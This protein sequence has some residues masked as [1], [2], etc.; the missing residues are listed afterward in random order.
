[1]ALQDNLIAYYDLENTTDASGNGNTLTNTGSVAFSAA[2]IDN[3]AVFDGSNKRLGVTSNNL[4]FDYNGDYTWAW[5]ININV[6]TGYGWDHWT[7]TGA[8]R[9]PI[10]ARGSGSVWD[11]YCGGFSGVNIISTTLSTST[12]YFFVLVKTGSNWELFRDN[13]SIG[14][15]TS[16][17]A[18]YSGNQF[19][20][21]AAADSFG[22]NGNNTIDGF[23]LWNKA[24][25]STE[26]SQLWNSGNGLR[27]SDFPGG[28]SPRG[29]ILLDW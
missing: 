8:G 13:T 1:M 20:I 18:S 4:S 21:G 22:G 6:H 24:M 23:G 3:G 2:K 26:R 19:A 28:A 16:G 14:T 25:D 12:W 15:A 11:M 27:Y 29:G 9:R 17:S 10:F 5:W 7:T